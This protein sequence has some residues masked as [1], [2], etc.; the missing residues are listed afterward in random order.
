MCIFLKN[1]AVK[2]FTKDKFKALKIIESILIICLAII[3]VAIY[4]RAKNVAEINLTTASID[5]VVVTQKI[6]YS[7]RFNGEEKVVVAEQSEAENIIKE[8]TADLDENIDVKIE[9]AEVYSS[10]L[11]TVSEEEAKSILNELKKAKVEEYKAQQ[12]EAE[13]AAKE[14]EEAAQKEAER[15]A[16]E[17]KKATATIVAN[18]SGWKLEI[19]KIGL[20]GP[21]AEGTSQEIINKYIGHFTETVKDNGNVGFAAHNGGFEQN[22]FAN[23]NQLTMGDSIFYTYNGV[24][25]EYQV[26]YK[27][28]IN[29][30]D[31]SKLQ[32]TTDER[33]TLITCVSY[34]QPNLRLCIQAV[35]VN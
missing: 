5:E 2:F 12:L 20:V 17:E 32:Y 33:V 21:I 28:V 35:R 22:Y 16:E 24:T 6:K 11:E 19:P 14:A 9:F 10:D 4:I 31:W 7:I 30:T 15:K 3:L 18:A 25:K 13:Q 27:E 1:K 8:L 29:D 26:V 34:N 23:I